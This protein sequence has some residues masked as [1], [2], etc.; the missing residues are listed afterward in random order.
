VAALVTGAPAPPGFAGERLTATADALRRR[1]ARM[2]ARSW[3]AFARAW[4]AGFEQ[5]VARWAADHPTDPS[6]RVD[7]ARFLT[8]H[9]A[10]I[11]EPAAR[12]E[13]VAARR[14]TGLSRPGRGSSR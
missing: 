4:G 2:I 7:G 13:I 10:D 11:T 8:E 9:A 6:P 3:P 5:D 1:R 12:D 14:L